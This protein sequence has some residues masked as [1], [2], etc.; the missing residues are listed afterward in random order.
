MRPT[1]IDVNDIDP[2]ITGEFSEEQRDS[3][4]SSQV[5]PSGPGPSQPKNE[6]FR[7]SGTSGVVPR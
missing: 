5:D 1:R 3:N 2:V 6:R 4:G 7:A